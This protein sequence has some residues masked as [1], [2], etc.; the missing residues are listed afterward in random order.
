MHPLVVPRLER[1]RVVSRTAERAVFART[2]FFVLYSV[3]KERHGREWC[4]HRARPTHK[5]C[6]CQN[7]ADVVPLPGDCGHRWLRN[8]LLVGDEGSSERSANLSG[9]SVP[10]KP[11]FPTPSV[12]RRAVKST[13]SR[14]ACQPAVEVFL[15]TPTVR[16]GSGFDDHQVASLLPAS[17]HHEAIM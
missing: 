1:T 17:Q 5:A 13:S 3:F 4:V 6:G 16:E 10:V 8:G 9:V 7:P 15:G 12:V 2:G 11:G 14:L